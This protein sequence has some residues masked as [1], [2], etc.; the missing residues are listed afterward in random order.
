MLKW[1]PRRAGLARL[2]CAVHR[3]RCAGRRGAARADDGVRRLRS[4]RAKPACRA[5][6]TAVGVAA[7]SASR[8]PSHR[9]RGRGHRHDWRPARYRGAQPQRGGHRRRLD[10]TDPR[11]AGALRRFLGCGGLTGLSHRRDSREQPRVDQRHVGDRVP[12]R[13]WQALLGQRDAGPRHHPSA[14]RRGGDLLHRVQLYA[15]AGE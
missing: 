2:D 4:D 5:P 11:A 13:P 10:G 15:A 14:P 9:A 6:G 3:P 1:D 8:P 7:L 12:A